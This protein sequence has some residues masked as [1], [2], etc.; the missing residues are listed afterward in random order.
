ML[1]VCS[2]QPYQVSDEQQCPLASAASNCANCTAF[3]PRVTVCANHRLLSI[4][5][6]KNL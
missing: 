1:D 6:E 2:V 4:E 5:A 3:G